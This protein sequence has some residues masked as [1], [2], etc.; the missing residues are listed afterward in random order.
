M[1]FHELRIRLTRRAETDLLDILNVSEQQWGRRQ[2]I[3]Y[4]ENFERIFSVLANEPT[5]GRS[6]DELVPR[7]RSHPAGSHVI[8][9]LALSDELFVIR[10]LH[11]RRDPRREEWQDPSD[12]A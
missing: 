9:Y 3:A 4:S 10:I 12:G 1:S 2:R 7:L 8:Y 6:R 5:I 11:G